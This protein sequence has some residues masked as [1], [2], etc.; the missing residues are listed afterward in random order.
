MSNTAW[1]AVYEIDDEEG[2]DADYQG[3]ATREEAEAYA[4]T[5]LPLASG[6]RSYVYIVPVPEEWYADQTDHDDMV[7]LWDDLPR[8]APENW[9]FLYGDKES[10]F[11][12]GASK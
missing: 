1:F 6:D 5:L 7:T 11:S 2:Y 4:Q 8:I 3:F 9:T 10:Y 12:E